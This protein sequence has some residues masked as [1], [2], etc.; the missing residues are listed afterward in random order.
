M[1]SEVHVALLSKVLFALLS[2]SAAYGLWRYI[3][4]RSAGKMGKDTLLIVIYVLSRI[5]L[6]LT[7][8][9]FLQRFVISSDPYYYRLE[10]EN[11][12]SGKVPIRDF[13]YP[14]GPLLLPCI[15]PFYVLLGRSL[16]GI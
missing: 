2:M 5:G 3:H 15:L 13:Y 9:L 14:Y 11:F 6:W 4:R 10:L 16:A 12:L 1:N 8:A 7:F